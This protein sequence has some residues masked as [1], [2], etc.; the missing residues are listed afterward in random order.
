MI[1]Q[2]NLSFIDKETKEFLYF[3]M[4]VKRMQDL[5]QHNTIP[6]PCEEVDTFYKQDLNMKTPQ[7]V[8]LVG[9]GISKEAYDKFKQIL[10]SNKALY[11][12]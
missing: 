2:V 6:N 3:I 7:I 12:S 5:E 10:E 4:L 9:D 8:S 1:G 11:T